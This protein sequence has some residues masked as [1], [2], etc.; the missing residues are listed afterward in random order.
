MARSF[1]VTS[2]TRTGSVIA[3]SVGFAAWVG[4]READGHD[5]DD[6]LPKLGPVPVDAIVGAAAGIAGLIVGAKYGGHD[7][8]AANVLLGAGDGA[9]AVFGVS[10]GQSLG[11]KIHEVVKGTGGLLPGTGGGKKKERA[12]LN[13]NGHTAEIRDAHG[14]HMPVNAPASNEF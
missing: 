6:L 13:G 9:G 2:L 3:A 1:Y 10:G 14:R 11:H 12:Q 5:P 4:Y 7:S 8:M